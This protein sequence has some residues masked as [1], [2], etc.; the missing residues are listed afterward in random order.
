MSFLTNA[1]GAQNNYTVTPG[2]PGDMNVVDQSRNLKERADLGATNYSNANTGLNSLAQMLINQAN[3]QGPNLAN[4][5][6]QQATGQNVANQASLMAGQRGAATN[7]GLVARNAGVLGAQAQQQSAGQASINNMQQQINAQNQLGQVYG[8]QGSLANQ[9]LGLNQGALTNQNQLVTN[10]KL[11]A[12]QANA[13]IAQANSSVNNQL[14]GSVLNAGGAALTGGAKGGGGA[15]GSS[16]GGSYTNGGIF[17]AEGGEIPDM[18]DIPDHI[19]HIASIRYP[20]YAKGGKTKKQDIVVSPGEAIVKPGESI[21]D[22]K[23]VPGKPKFKGN[24][25]RNDTVPTKV[26]THSIVI[27][28]SIMQSPNAPQLAYDFVSRIRAGHHRPKGK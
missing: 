28:N 23:I 1:F 12:S 9:F 18:S 17:A 25:Y 5:I 3:G 6:L 8:T 11:G 7:A 2:L 13:G 4:A 24:D 10:A 22:A 15:K 16:A 21:K 14:M 26:P 19:H 20:G 27:P